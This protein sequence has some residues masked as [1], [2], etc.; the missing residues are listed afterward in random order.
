MQNDCFPDTPPEWD[1][2]PISALADI[3]PR[4][5]VKKG[6]ELPFIEMAAVAEQFG[7]IL[8]IDRRKLEGSGLARFKVGDTL[9][10]KIT[11]CPENGKVAFVHDLP[12]QYGIGSTEFIVLSPK[13]NCDPRYLY[14]LVCA[15]AVRGRAASR[16]EGSTGRQRVPEDVFEKRLLVPVPTPG[17]QSDIARILDAVDSA[18]PGLPKNG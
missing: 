8:S 7:G 17:E 2:R 14:H 11:P 9:F 16:M 1:K 5:P 10:A 3:N 4:Y 13:A 12:T 15:H 18:I 6:Q